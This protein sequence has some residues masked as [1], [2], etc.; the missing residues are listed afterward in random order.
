MHASHGVLL[1]LQRLGISPFESAG[2]IEPG[3][4]FGRPISDVLALVSTVGNVGAGLASKQGLGELLHLDA[5]VVDVE[6]AVDHM[7]RSSEHPREGVTV[8]RP[9]GMAGM[10]WAGGIR[11]HVFHVDGAAVADVGSSV[12]GHAL[13]DHVFDHFV[14]P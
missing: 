10:E 9:P 14:E 7:V 12:P 6:L 3:G 1:V 13:V 11:A 8:G 5:T 2:A 4:H